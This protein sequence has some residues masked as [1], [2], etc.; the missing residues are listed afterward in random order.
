VY[1]GGRIKIKMSRITF[2]VLFLFFTALSAVG[3]FFA[4][5]PQPALAQGAVELS[6]TPAA[7]DTAYLIPCGRR[8]GQGLESEPCT[9]CH[10]VVA[11]KRLIDYMMRIMVVVAVAVI[12]AMGVLYILS[13][14]NADLN[15]K[16]KEG[17]MAVVYG[18]VFMLSAWL[19]VSTVLRFLANENVINGGDGFL[20][21]VTGDGV[22]GLEC[23]T[24]SSGNKVTLAGG[25]VASTGGYAAAGVCQPG[26]PAGNPC[27]PQSLA[28]T[29]F[30]G[31][32]VNTWSAICQAESNGSVTVSSGTDRCT[33]AAR[34]PVS[35]GLFQIN[36]SANSIGG[37][38]CP[39]AFDKPFTGSDKN[40]RVV[41]QELYNQC[42]A[43][44]KNAQNN[45]ATACRL[46]S[47]NATNTGPWGAARRCNIPRKL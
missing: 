37:L 34:T 12:V 32:S 45:I 21:I 15:K 39:K 14:V 46:A 16:A 41:N 18:L 29:C 30:G 1:N 42:V 6:N 44:A 35:F 5:P 3:S 31:S 8:D 24:E 36:I 25:S 20:G 7:E 26:S 38:N 40:C 33:D 11:G 27:S 4:F 28:S 13:G 23:S 22:Y 19:I 17:L 9:A 43:A 2:S 47:P 10:A